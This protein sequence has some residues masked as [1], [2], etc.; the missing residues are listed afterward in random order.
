MQAG[1][2]FYFLRK[3]W[4]WKWHFE[5]S[6]RYLVLKLHLIL[7]FYGLKLHC[8]ILKYRAKP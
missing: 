1:I 7:K 6:E 8:T 5:L 3:N 4:R 2:F